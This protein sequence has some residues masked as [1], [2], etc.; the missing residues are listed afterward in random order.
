LFAELHPLTA[1]HYLASQI[2]WD[3]RFKGDS[4]QG[5]FVTIDGIDFAVE[6]GFNKKWYSHKFNSTAVKYELAVSIKTGDIV[7]FNGPFR[8]GQHDL[9]IFRYHLRRCLED[10]EKVIADRGYRGDRKVITPCDMLPNNEEVQAKMSNFRGR[11]E[12]INGRLTR[13]KALSDRWRHRLD[14]HHLAFR[15]AAVLTQVMHENGRP[16]YQ[17]GYNGDGGSL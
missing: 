17:V 10:G 1:P 11:H 14:K 4:F 15:S 5:C 3:N 13:W 7:A 6:S 9:S 16:S 8:G 12:C 2:L